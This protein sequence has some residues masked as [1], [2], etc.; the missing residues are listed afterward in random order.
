MFQLQQIDCELEKH[1]WKGR[2]VKI[3]RLGDLKEGIESLHQQG[4]FDRDFYQEWLTGFDFEPPSSDLQARSIIVVAVPQPQIRVTFADHGGMKSLIVPPTYL[5]GREVDLRVMN[6]LESVLSP[7]GYRIVQATLPKKQLAVR[8]GLGAYGKNN[9]CYVDGM[10]SFHRLTAFFSDLPCA[11]DFWQPPVMMTLC[12][13]CSACQRSCPSG[14]I[15]EDRFLLHAE[16]CVTFLNE[17]TWEKPF[18]E[19]VETAWHN[20]LVGCMRCQRAC[21]QDKEYWDWVEQG[22]K[23]SPSETELLLQGV[24]AEKL[25]DAVRQKLEQFDMIGLLEVIPRNLSVFYGKSTVE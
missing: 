10:G 19:W 16:R 11:E 12:E 2:I 7:Q 3:E 24:P 1:S 6:A 21:P 20:S 14:A 9:I 5:Y 25:P 13:N 17:K 18:P 15:G 23:F 8:S 22:A 4:L